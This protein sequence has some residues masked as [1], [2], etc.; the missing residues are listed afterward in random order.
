MQRANQQGVQL[1][2]LR[3]QTNVATVKYR[4]ALRLPAKFGPYEPPAAAQPTLTAPGAP[5]RRATYTSRVRS[6]CKCRTPR[7]G[8]P[9]ALAPF[10]NTRTR[11]QHSNHV[12]QPSTRR[13]PGVAC[14]RTQPRTHAKAP[15]AHATPHSM[16]ASS[17]EGHC[18]RRRCSRRA[19][20]PL[21]RALPPPRV[22]HLYPE[23]NSQTTHRGAGCIT[24]TAG[25]LT[26]I[27]TTRRALAARHAPHTNNPAQHVHWYSTRSRG[28][29]VCVLG[30]GFRV[31][32]PSMQ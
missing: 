13:A 1:S 32:L 14:L 7:L 25:Y 21:H 2:R 17:A 30:S 29:Y 20:M 28:A 18:S 4:Y 9:P 26:C 10:I 24:S 15:S 22:T 31:S 5:T 16:H 23:C 19:S 8:H 3:A 11:M 27:A 6:M 12:G